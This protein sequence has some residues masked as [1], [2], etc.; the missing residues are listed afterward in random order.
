MKL[1][2]QTKITSCA[3]VLEKTKE[4]FLYLIGIFGEHSK[5]AVGG[6]LWQ[7]VLSNIAQNSHENICVGVLECLRPAS[8]SKKRDF[9]TAVFL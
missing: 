5:A 8:V 1:G 6:I 2:I 3:I 7:Q 4:V 9:D